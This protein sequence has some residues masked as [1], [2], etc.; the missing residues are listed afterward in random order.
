MKIIAITQARMGS[1]RLPGKVL[2]EINGISLLKIH[3]DRV[4]KSKLISSH[5]LATSNN[6]SDDILVDYAKQN[7]ITCFRGDENNVLERFIECLNNYKNIDFVVRLTADC[8]LIDPIVIDECIKLI[9]ETKVDYV[10]NCIE[11][12]FPDGIDVEV[13]NYKSLLIASENAKLNSEKEHV[14]PYIWKNSNLKGGS[15]FSALTLKNNIDY[16][17]IRLTVDEPND[18][19][20]VNE[21]IN[22]FGLHQPWLIYANEII[23][24]GNVINQSIARNEGYQKSIKK[25]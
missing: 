16:S 20:V 12:T 21:L 18:L 17:Y 10:S 7:Q 25:D 6:T 2:K 14:T 13:F 24:N 1:T 8:P 11:P 19:I 23:K 3:F 22:K 5:I 15:I 4:S 9:I